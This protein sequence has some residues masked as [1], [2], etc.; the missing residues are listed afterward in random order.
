MNTS[1]CILLL[2]FVATVSF[3]A[4]ATD[5][6]RRLRLADNA[7]TDTNR[8]LQLPS[9]PI[10]QFIDAI[11]S[12]LDE[13][14]D[15]TEL[16]LALASLEGDESMHWGYEH[17]STEKCLKLLFIL[18]P[19]YKA[20]KLSSICGETITP[21]PT[22]QPTPMSMSMSMPMIFEDVRK[23]IEAMQ[24]ENDGKMKS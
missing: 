2:A 21:Q 3:V 7:D 8:L 22:P 4:A 23:L 17:I 15:E 16:M 24:L 14:E 5:K 19:E 13:K 9:S 11:V 12:N 10:E 18:L 1:I 20:S 6:P